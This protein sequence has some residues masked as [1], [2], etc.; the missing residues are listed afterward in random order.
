[1]GNEYRDIKI[2]GGDTGTPLNISKRIAY[3]G[4]FLLPAKSKVIDCGCG[5]GHYTL[6]LLKTFSVNI[7][8]I[9]YQKDKVLSTRNIP[10]LRDRIIHGDI[11]HIPYPDR[12]FDVALLNE[13]LEHIPDE[14]RALSEIHRVLVKGGLV[15][16]FAPNRWYPFETHGVYLKKTGKNVPIWVPFIPYVPLRVGKIIFDYW[17]RNYWQS[18]MVHLIQTTQFKVVE[19]AWMWQ[20]FENISG[21][22]PTL[23]R[24]FRPILRFISKLCQI[25]P[26]VKR[27]GVSQVIVARK[28]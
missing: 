10:E 20:T 26:V 23:V 2:N 28:V 9:E 4:R 8:G 1:M 3:I 25:L 21:N 16:I 17:A 19:R 12:Y 18:E 27:F 22:Q 14:K 5:E 24:H 11:E 15:I 7:V 6:S 13:V